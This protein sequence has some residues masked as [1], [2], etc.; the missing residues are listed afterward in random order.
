MSLP[1]NLNYLGTEDL[2]ALTG[3]TPDYWAR[4]CH[5]GAIA[6]VKLGNEWRVEQTVFEAF[7]KGGAGR[8]A[9]ARPGRTARQRRRSA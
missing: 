1:K 8:A 5:S 4:L 9:V 7:M 2:A 3:K 6:A